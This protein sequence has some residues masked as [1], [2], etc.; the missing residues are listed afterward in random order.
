MP[1][2]EDQIDLIERLK[3]ELGIDQR[4]GQSL[5]E[6]THERGQAIGIDPISP[7]EGRQIVE[8]KFNPIV[9]KVIAALGG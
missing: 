3:Q 8:Q 7:S 1:L 6:Q 9:I 4:L 2:S 5:S